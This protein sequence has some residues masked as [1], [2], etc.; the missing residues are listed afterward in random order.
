MGRVI[1]S[2]KKAQGLFGGGAMVVCAFVLLWSGVASDVSNDTTLNG[3]VQRAIDIDAAIPD[4][5]NNGR[6]VVAAGRL[7]SADAYEDDYLKP[8]SALVVQRHVEMLQWVEATT[9]EAAT[10]KYSLEWVEGQV[11]FFKFK[12]TQGHENPLL[13]LSPEQYRAPQSRFGGFDG[14]RLL[15]LIQKL[16]RLP[17][18]P[19]LFK[20]ISQEIV[21]NKIVVRRNPSSDLPALGDMRVWY[22]VLSQGDYTVLT[23]QEDERSLVGASSSSALFIQ[24][25]LLS[26]EDFISEA[27]VDSEQSFRGMLYLGGL[28]LFAGCLSLMMPHAQKFDL[29]PHLNVTGAFAVVIV[30]A[31]GAFSVTALFF[32]LSLAQ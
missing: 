10:P 27:E 9:S 14:G 12:V 6:L 23:V 22:D 4:P 8:N 32:L 20:N 17:L 25:G 29:N 31:S 26:S 18:T 15:P 5:N 13:Q 28:L 1:G 2:F 24:R 30:S 3:L 11:D 19:E 7:R 21:D 16:D